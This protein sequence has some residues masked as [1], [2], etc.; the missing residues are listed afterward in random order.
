MKLKEKSDYIDDLIEKAA[1]EEFDSIEVDSKSKEQQWDELMSALNQMGKRKKPKKMRMLVATASACILLLFSL[2]FFQ[3]DEGSAFG[4][5]KRI[6]VEEDGIITKVQIV[7]DEERENELD[8][9]INF[10]IGISKQVT[11]QTIEDAIQ[12]V[13]QKIFIPSYLPESTNLL[14]VRI[15]YQSD[16]TIGRMEQIYSLNNEVIKITQKSNNF[17]SAYHFDNEDSLITQEPPIDKDGVFIHYKDNLNK[18]M[19]IQ[20]QFTFTIEA[21]LSQDEIIKIAKSFK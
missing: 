14:E 21:N 19:W 16:D 17:D 2:S 15:S 8:S 1:K 7:S 4:W 6:F 18:L 20:E 13:N 12:H 11:F 5:L 9:T 10:D 3:A